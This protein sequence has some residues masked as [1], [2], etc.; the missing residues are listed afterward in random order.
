MRTGA[1]S[2]AAA[3]ALAGTV[4]AN[5][6]LQFDVNSF[7]AQSMSSAGAPT[8]FG[9]VSHTGSVNF[10][11]GNGTLEGVFI[12]SAPAGPFVNAGLSGFTMSG[13]TGRIDLVDG[14]VTGGN[15]ALSLNSGDTYTAQITPGVGAVSTFIGGGFKI[16]SIT[17]GGLF[18]DAAF[19]N[20]DV[21]QWFNNQGINGL[22]GSLGPSRVTS[23]SVPIACCT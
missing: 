18:S 9:G 14:M 5:P 22:L 19:G 11:A 23:K 15:L 10:S 13:F 7:H 6:V 16:E 4:S 21:S 12:Q 20:V 2:V 8:A 3:M 1:L 17:H